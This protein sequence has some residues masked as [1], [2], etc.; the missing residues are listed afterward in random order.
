MNYFANIKERCN[1]KP[2]WLFPTA[3]LTRKPESLLSAYWIRR[4]Q[5]KPSLAPMAGHRSPSST[6]IASQKRRS[7]KT[8]SI[9]A[10]PAMGLSPVV[11]ATP[12]ARAPS[13]STRHSCRIEITFT[14]RFERP[15]NA[16]VAAISQVSSSE[17]PCERRV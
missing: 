10:A 15:K 9:A 17:K 4:P 2:Q 16:V 3:T 13:D 8:L 12:S 14:I 6:T 1:R 7:C 5:T 11:L